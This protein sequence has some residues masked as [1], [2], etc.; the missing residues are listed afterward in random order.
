MLRRFE[1]RGK[2][3]QGKF[4]PG[5]RRCTDTSQTPGSASPSEHP[6]HHPRQLTHREARL[7]RALGTRT[8]FVAGQGRHRASTPRGAGG[9]RRAVPGARASSNRTFAAAVKPKGW[10]WRSSVPGASNVVAVGRCAALQRTPPGFPGRGS[11]AGDRRSNY[12]PEGGIV[13]C[14]WQRPGTRLLASARGPGPPAESGTPA[15][16]RGRTHGEGAPVTYFSYSAL[17]RS[18]RESLC[19]CQSLPCLQVVRRTTSSP[20]WT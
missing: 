7:T 10:G 5:L 20:L 1:P 17:S 9:G 15:R 11:L 19:F 2:G 12:A 13:T 6:S 8:N 18:Q 3:R 14:G 4:L 16:P